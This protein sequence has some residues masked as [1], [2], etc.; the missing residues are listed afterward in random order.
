MAFCKGCGAEIVWL[1]TK[2]GKNM[3]CNAEKT[4]II[5]ESGEVITGYVPHW[6]TCSQ[7]HTFRGKNEGG[8]AR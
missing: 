5:T 4:T 2:S 6:G 1:K 3:P 7:S 8:G